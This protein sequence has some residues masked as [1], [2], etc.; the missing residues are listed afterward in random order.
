[1]PDVPRDR[2]LDGE[3]R[4]LVIA[5]FAPPDHLAERLRSGQRRQSDREDLLYLVRGQ[6]HLGLG[7]QEPDERADPEVRG[8]DVHLLQLSHDFDQPGAEVDLLLGLA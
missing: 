5:A 3:Y 8:R 4:H 6:Y 1:V 2:T 7:R